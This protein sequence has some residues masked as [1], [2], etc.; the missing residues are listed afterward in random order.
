MNISL[1]T[2]ANDDVTFGK[3]TIVSNEIKTLLSNYNNTFSS[4]EKQ[5]VQSFIDTLQE[6]GLWNKITNLYLPCLS[7]DLEHSLLDVKSSYKSSSPIIDTLGNWKGKDGSTSI[8]TFEKSKGITLINNVEFNQNNWLTRNIDNRDVHF[9]LR[10]S[11]YTSI[12][13]EP[14]T[15]K[16]IVWID[17]PY[18]HPFGY[19]KNIKSIV[20]DNKQAI[21]GINNGSNYPVSA[22]FSMKSLEE[23]K[24]NQ[25]AWS[26]A[27]A[28]PIDTTNNPIT[29]SATTSLALWFSE[30][31]RKVVSWQKIKF[32]TYGQALSIDEM[33]T[34]STAIDNLMSVIENNA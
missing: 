9:G 12:T 20:I 15:Y 27:D 4:K 3:V 26:T 30:W 2:I 19:S 32:M 5:A 29:V 22:F 7:G 6:T 21:E 11:G 28:A 8:A 24:V 13:G 18:S 10:H 16:P 25:Y 14:A 1:N 17:K 23:G 33:K 31:D 34:Y